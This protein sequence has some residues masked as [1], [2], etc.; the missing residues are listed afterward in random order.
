[1]TSDGSSLRVNVDDGKAVVDGSHKFKEGDANAGKTPKIIAGAYSNS[2][3]GTQATALYNIDATTGRWCC[4]PRR[5]TA[6]STRSAR[7]A[8][9]STAMSPSTSWPQARTRTRLAVHG[10]RALLGRSQDR[11]GDDG[12]QD[13]Q[14][15]GFLTDWPG[16]IDKPPAVSVLADPSRGCP[17]RGADLFHARLVTR[18]ACRTA[19]GSAG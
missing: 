19:R 9:S 12:R 3:K 2:V 17:H 6:R 11:Q 18:R 16:W 10:R 4:R 1:M 8:S 15:A 7:W 14:P 5:M 13:R